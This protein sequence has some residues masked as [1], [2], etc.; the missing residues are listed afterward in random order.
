MPDKKFSALSGLI[1]FCF[2]SLA[3]SHG[4]VD[5]SRA[6]LCAQGQNSGCGSVIYEP[7]SVEGDDRF[8]ESGPPDGQIASAG[9]GRFS[10]LDAQ[11]PTRWRKTDLDS[12]SYTFNWY[13]TAPHY[14]RD[15]RYFITKPNWNSSQPLSRSA[16]DLTPFCSYSG[17][18]RPPSNVSHQCVIPERN[19]YHIILAVWD[20]G[21]TSKSFY[22][23]LDVN[24]T[25]SGPVPEW[26]D[27]GDINPSMDL[28]P[29]DSVLVRLFDANGELFD[30][31]IEMTI[32][33]E[34]N[35]K[36]NTWPK[37]LAEYIPTQANDLLAGI[38][39]S[40]GDIVPS[41]G[42]NDI[43]ASRTSSVIRAEIDLLTGG[44][45]PPEISASA[46]ETE[47]TAGM[48]LNLNVTVTTNQL[49]DVTAE[50]HYQGVSVARTSADIQGTQTLNIAL[51]DPE[52]GDYRLVVTGT[53]YEYQQET[54][55]E[56]I[57]I[58]VTDPG[59]S[60]YVYPN[61]RGSYQAGTI[62]TGLDGN[63]YECVIPNW[64]NGSE[65]HYAPG[66]GFYWQQAWVQVG[67]GTPPPPPSEAD[68][69]YPDGRGYYGHGTIVEGRDGNL[70]RCD[71]PGWCNSRSSFYYAPGTGLAWSSAWTAL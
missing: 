39:N 66:T 13:F 3:L 38:S 70:Y 40:A 58:T 42:R 24:L 51:N 5:I 4:Y 25:S 17:G 16:F 7:Q 68:Y 36:A 34:A 43:F 56:T 63:I 27:I 59:T 60:E 19:G 47:F 46:S 9:L 8:P 62:V 55:Q 30:R 64:C 67:T 22:H 57:N 35:G 23:V 2:S 61:G 48:P 1:L 50:L 49:L 44:I 69:V 12:G 20:V 15:W 65:W 54:V 26:I 6:K 18:F 71:I 45:L 52:A 53:Q 31:N 32:N 29:G 28:Y 21:D 11:T 14:T 33:S 37:L 41:F 10:Q